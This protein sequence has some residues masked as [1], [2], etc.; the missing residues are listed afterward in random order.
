MISLVYVIKFVVSCGFGHIN[1]KKSLLKNF[2]SLTDATWVINPVILMIWLRNF[3][4]ILRM[5][6]I[7]NMQRLQ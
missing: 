7:F 2:V 3:V 4:S 1:W 6:Y 5:I